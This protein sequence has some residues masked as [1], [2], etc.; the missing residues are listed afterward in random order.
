MLFALIVIVSEHMEM[1]A[2]GEPLA[3]DARYR[4][5]SI[6][7]IS[8]IIWEGLTLKSWLIVGVISYIQNDVHSRC[9]RQG[10]GIPLLLTKNF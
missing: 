10:G 9:L 2:K 1:W 6:L 7:P 5:S 4:G 8:T 3:L